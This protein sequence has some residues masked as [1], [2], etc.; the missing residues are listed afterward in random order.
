M[1]EQNLTN[2][3][4]RP[5]EEAR[6][7]R[8][9]G[10]K[11]ANEAKRRNRMLKSLAREVLNGRPKVKAAALK[12]FQT[13]GFGGDR[14]DITVGMAILLKAGIEAMDGDWD[15]AKLLFSTAHQ[16]NMHEQNEKD[17]IR[18]MAERGAKVDVRVNAE[19]ASVMNEI[20]E[21][22]AGEDAP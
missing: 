12:E 4:D 11:A 22:L 2:I 20:R 18:L 17:R 3:A 15:A 13:A 14:D 19:G 6:A 21:R 10:A 1:N 16:P 7:I 9:K 5:A 8:A